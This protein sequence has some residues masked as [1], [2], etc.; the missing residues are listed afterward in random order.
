MSVRVEQADHKYNVPKVTSPNILFCP[1]DKQKNEKYLMPA[2]G[3][4]K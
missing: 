1:T 4:C 3:S 2:E